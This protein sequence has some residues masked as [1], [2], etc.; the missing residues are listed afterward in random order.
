[1]EQLSEK[2]GF[3]ILTT[4]PS[5]TQKGFTTRRLLFV[6]MAESAAFSG[7]ESNDVGGPFQS[8]EYSKKAMFRNAT[9]WQY[10]S[11]QSTEQVFSTLC[12][13][14][15]VSQITSRTLDGHMIETMMGPDAHVF[16]W[17][18]SPPDYTRAHTHMHANAQGTRAAA[19]ARFV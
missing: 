1:M 8:T 12:I 10:S 4:M 17:S 16:D 6:G 5:P 19:R 14:T 2:R 3:I 15:D 13:E 18:V 11:R 9:E 7:H